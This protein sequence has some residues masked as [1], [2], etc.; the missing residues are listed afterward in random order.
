MKPAMLGV[1]TVVVTGRVAAHERRHGAGSVQHRQHEQHDD[2][3]PKG[4]NGAQARPLQI[5]AVLETGH[6]KPW[7]VITVAH[8]RVASSLA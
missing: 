2:R 4:L 5:H 7:P 1:S 8:R 3:E 6:P